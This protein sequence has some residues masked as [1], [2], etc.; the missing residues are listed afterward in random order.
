[1]YHNWKNRHDEWQCQAVQALHQEKYQI[2][3]QS[4][5]CLHQSEYT[6]QPLSQTDEVFCNRSASHILII[7]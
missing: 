4:H 7:D 5:Q 2:K 3:S 6:R 1:M